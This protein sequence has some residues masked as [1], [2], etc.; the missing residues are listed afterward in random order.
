MSL[1]GIMVKDFLYG[2][3]RFMDDGQAGYGVEDL[4]FGIHYARGLM[5]E[6]IACEPLDG[7]RLR[8]FKA[9]AER[10]LKEIA[11]EAENSS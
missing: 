9:W 7:W 5:E 3:G 8:A 1:C 6:G 4:E 11:S 10:R 2:H